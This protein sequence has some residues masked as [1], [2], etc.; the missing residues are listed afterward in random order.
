MEF[1]EWKK[2]QRV[3]FTS[4]FNSTEF[5]CV[6]SAKGEWQKIAK[7]LVEKLQK[8]RSSVGYPLIITSGFRTAEHQQRLKESG[9]PTAKGISSHELGIAVDIFYNGDDKL[10]K[11][12][13]KEFPCVGV[14]KN[15]LHG[16]L[17]SD[18]KRFWS[19]I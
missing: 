1:Y 6:G 12:F 16:D 13:K 2:G 3:Q 18:K 7:P 5:D 19:Y 4:N 14:A 8:I 11:L 17:R 15:F 9:Y 10:L